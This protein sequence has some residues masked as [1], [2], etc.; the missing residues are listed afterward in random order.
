MVLF[1]LCFELTHWNNTY[2]IYFIE[3]VLKTPKNKVVAVQENNRMI[4]YLT[5]LPVTLAI[6][7]IYDTYGRKKPLILAFSIAVIVFAVFPYN[8]NRYIYYFLNVLTVPI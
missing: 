1:F 8:T 2:D 3:N 7:T 6:G 4:Q 5:Q